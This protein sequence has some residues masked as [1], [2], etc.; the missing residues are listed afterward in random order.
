M[1][2]GIHAYQATLGL[3]SDVYFVEYPRQS[4]VLR[5]P[6]YLVQQ[7][8][9][10][11]TNADKNV[12][13]A[14]DWS[15][16]AKSP[17]GLGILPDYPTWQISPGVANFLFKSNALAAIAQPLALRNL[18]FIGHSR[19]G[20][21]LSDVNDILGTN[22]FA[23]E[24]FTT[25]D[26]RAHP[27]SSDVIPHVSN[28]VM[29]ADNYYQTFD[30]IAYGDRL[31]GAFNRSPNLFDSF[32]S[33]PFG[34]TGFPTVSD[35]HRNIRVWYHRTI[36]KLSLPGN[37]SIQALYRTW[38]TEEEKEGSLTGYF[39]EHCPYGYRPS[40]GYRSRRIKRPAIHLAYDPVAKQTTF[41]SRG[42]ATGL[43][44]LEYSTNLN[45]WITT[46]G[47]IFD[48]RPFSSSAALDLSVASSS[49]LRLRSS[50]P[51]F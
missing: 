30:T 36:S 25:L 27:I 32:T 21:L 14:F 10:T 2:R 4:G 5:E 46:N 43:Y 29:F 26:P 24:H 17:L 6:Q 15:Y 9:S 13:V 34:G 20:S 35:G 39:F 41:S 45:Q 50:N 37:D 16:Y 19:G 38:F 3:K 11:S 18:H 12:V 31:D 23:V 22:G 47:L 28:N 33:V 1:C 51:R 49:F 42:D 40:E 7:I 8:T 44:F 48:G